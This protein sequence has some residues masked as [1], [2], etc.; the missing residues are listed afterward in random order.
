[1]DRLA[2]APGPRIGLRE[3]WRPFKPTWKV[4]NA[5]RAALTTQ[6]GALWH[7]LEREDAA[8]L[9]ALDA[10]LKAAVSRDLSGPRG[11]PFELPDVAAWVREA[12]APGTWGI[13]QILATGATPA[14][15]SEA[16]PLPE[17]PAPAGLALQILDRLRV[18]SLDRLE[19]EGRA[20]APA[21]LAR[22]DLV[23][24]LKT[25]GT[26]VVWIGEQIVCMEQ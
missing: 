23:A 7:W 11:V 21:G 14:E 17:P 6:A 26:R 25:A 3:A 5:K 9:L 12:L 20:V 4:C 2:D 19:R 18:A 10:L 8:R 1:M 16:R 22:K 13:A 24:Q 15:P